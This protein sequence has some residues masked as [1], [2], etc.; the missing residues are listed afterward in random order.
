MSY[1]YVFDRQNDNL[2][3]TGSVAQSATQ[4]RERNAVL[5][6]SDLMS[7]QCLEKAATGW[8]PGPPTPTRIPSATATDDASSKLGYNVLCQRKHDHNVQLWPACTSP[9]HHLTISPSHHLTISP[10]HHLT[11]SPSHHLTISCTSPSHHLTISP[12]HH[13]TISPSHHLTISPSHHLTISPSHHLTISPSHHLTI[14]PSHHLMY[15][16]I[17]PSHHLTISPSHHLTISCTSPSHHLTISPSH[18]LTISPSHHLTAYRGS[19]K[20]ALPY[21]AT[22]PTKSRLKGEL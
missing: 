11:I 22:F 7:A 14:S 10:S 15:L 13:L 6:R 1:F 16:T 21:N 4:C 9:S 8:S 17:S 5:Y 12:S 3:I 20:A 2:L 18:H 19:V